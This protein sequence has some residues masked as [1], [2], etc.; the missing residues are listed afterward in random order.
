MMKR[1]RDRFPVKTIEPWGLAL[2]VEGGG[3]FWNDAEEK[4][5]D[6]GELL[7]DTGMRCW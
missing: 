5:T 1:I 2:V 3:R 7:R 6:W 4:M